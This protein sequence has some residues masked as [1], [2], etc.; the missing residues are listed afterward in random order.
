VCF[1]RRHEVNFPPDRWPRVA[2]AG[3][4]FIQIISC[5][6]FYSLVAK[7]HQPCALKGIMRKSLQVSHD[8]KKSTSSVVNMQKGY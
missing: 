1:A 7:V 3:R 2:D 6:M 8:A 4:S 5:V